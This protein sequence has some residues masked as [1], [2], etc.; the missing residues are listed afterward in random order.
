MVERPLADACH[1]VRNRDSGET[2][3]TVECVV[4]DACH[5]VRNCD[6]GETCAIPECAFADANDTVRNHIFFLHVPGRITDQYI[7]TFIKQHT[8]Q[9]RIFCILFIH[10]YLFKTCAT[11]ECE[12]ADACH[13]VRNCDI[14]ES[15]ALEEC[16]LTDACHAVWNCD[17]GETG[18]AV[19][20]ITADACH[21][22]RNCNI[23]KTGAAVKC[24]SADACHAVLNYN[25]FDVFTVIIPRNKFSIL[26]IR[27][28]PCA[29]DYQRALAVERPGQVF[30]ALAGG[31]NLRFIRDRS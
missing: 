6:I 17:T 8:L 26:P 2:S 20:C 27:H 22:V 12:I 14:G 3:A 7:L 13:T 16:V 25:F 23:G 31:D 29:G 18:A 11:V 24:E 19:E 15:Y 30:A 5:A 21:T 1:T 28:L 9:R 10:I 4:A